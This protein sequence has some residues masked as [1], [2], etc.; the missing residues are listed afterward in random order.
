MRIQ[1]KRY[2]S[3]L[4]SYGIDLAKQIGWEYAGGKIP[5]T[6]FGIPNVKNNTND[7]YASCSLLSDGRT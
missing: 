3:D 4:A 5:G 7:I 2:M 1:K 6:P